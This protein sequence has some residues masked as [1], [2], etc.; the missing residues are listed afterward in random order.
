MIYKDKTKPIDERVKDLLIQMTIEEKAYQLTS[1][2]AYELV[3]NDFTFEVDKLKTKFPNGLGQITR[4]GG[5]TPTKVKDIPK[6]R[7]SIQEFFINN[8]RLG[9]PVMFHEESCSGAMFDGT[10][11]FPQAIGIASTFDDVLCEEMADIIGKELNAIGCNQTLAPLLDVTREPRWGRLEETFGEDVYLVSQ[12]GMAY[13]RGIQKNNVYST[14]KHFVA[15]GAAEKG[16]NWAPGQVPERTMREVYLAPFEAAI[17][18]ANLKSI[19]PAYQEN[20]GEPCHSSKKLLKKILRDEWKFNGL[21]VTDYSGLTLLESF[22]KLFPDYNSIAKRAIECEV[23]IELP[24]QAVYGKILA[25]E[26]K[27][28]NISKKDVDK[29]VERVLTKKFELGLFDNPYIKESLSFAMRSKESLDKS[30]EVARESIVLLENKNNILPLKKQ[31]KIAVIGPNGN[32]VRNQLGDYAFK[33][34]VESLVENLRDMSKNLDNNNA[35]GFTMQEKVNLNADILDNFIQEIEGVSVYK[36]IC[37]KV[38][39]DNV[40]LSL[41]SDIFETT[42]SMIEEAVNTAKKADVI[43]AVLGDKAGLEAGTSTGE[44]RDRS[45]IT[46]LPAQDRLLKELKKLGKPIILVLIVGRPVAMPWVKENID[47]VICAWLPGEMGG[48]AIAD[49][50][51]GDYNPGGKLPVTFPHNIGQI[52]IYYSHKPSGGAERMWGGYVDGP[53]DAIYHFGYGLSYT[54]FELY[55]FEIDKKEL[56]PT[57]TVKI[58]CKIK[59]VGDYKGSEVVQLYLRNNVLGVTRPVKELKGFKRVFLEPNKSAV[60]TFEVPI[61]ILAYYDEDMKFVMKKSNVDILIGTSSD[62]ILFKE[63]IKVNGEKEIKEKVFTTKVSLL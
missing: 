47:G 16:F 51:F 11:N 48:E 6:F 2:W 45:S 14:G 57:D 62:N 8:T 54:N 10:T 55:D 26:V 49:V 29:L 44:S 7:N 39:K 53:H 38:G 56:A 41:G 32:S 63:T 21:V 12:M 25:E 59:N 52:P 36:G 61:H 30:L 9:I 37:S 42:D 46:L 35:T 20:D 60:V 58:S 27:N 18:E 40:Y 13:I 5:S 33:A 43:V 24:T 17:K 31:Q 1:V 22:H 3:R 19:M 50:I 15:Y 4:I 23:D 34:H 28:G